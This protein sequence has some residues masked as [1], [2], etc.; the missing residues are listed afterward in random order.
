MTQGNL[1]K[2]TTENEIWQQIAA[3]LAQTPDPLEYSAVIEQQGHR[4]ILDIDIDLGGGFESGYETTSFTAPLPVDHG[5]R[6][7]IH[8]QDFTDGIGKFFGMQDILIGYPEFDKKLIVKT[9]DPHRVKTVFADAPVR[10]VIQRL[11]NFT[12]SI[13]TTAAPAD[14]EERL[15]LELVI[16]RGITKADE[17]RPIYTAFHAVLAALESNP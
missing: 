11:E 9:N 10:S 4:I 5:F 3:Q 16:E 8:E 7:A 12:F 2:G 6:F 17:L 13:T 15:L 1:I 14:S